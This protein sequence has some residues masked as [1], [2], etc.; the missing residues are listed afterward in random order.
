MSQIPTGIDEVFKELKTEITWLHARWIIYRQLFAHSEK[1]IGLLNDC[2][3]AFFYI[4]QDVLFGELQVIL[5]KLTDTARSGKHDNLSLEQLQERVEA[6]GDKNLASTLRNLLDDLHMKSR[7]FRLHRNK[8]LAHLDLTT[9]MQ[10]SLNPLPGISR[11]MIEDALEVIREYMNA[12]ERYYTQSETGYEHFIMHSD[13]DALVSILKYG[14]RHD[15]LLRQQKIS[16]D[17]FENTEWKD[18]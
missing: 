7:P 2:A 10:S 6:H 4:I 9:A 14:L 13:A 12:I 11:Q 17:D 3:S 15:E 8:R 16:W 1:R 5:S 18:A